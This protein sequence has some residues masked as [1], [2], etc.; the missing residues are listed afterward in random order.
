MTYILTKDKIEIADSKIWNSQ[1]FGDLLNTSFPKEVPQDYIWENK[2]YW[3]GWIADPEPI[4]LTKEEILAQ[5]ALAKEEI[6]AEAYR[7]ESDP[8]FFK[9]QRS[10]VEKQAWLDKVAEIK[11]R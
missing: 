3:L 5:E 1:L 11:G 8:L 4:A 6:R 10:E 9:W 2:G 7:N